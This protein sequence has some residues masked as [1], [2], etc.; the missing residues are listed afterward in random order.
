VATRSYNCEGKF[1]I[2]S[3]ESVSLSSHCRIP[4]DVHRE[5]LVLMRADSFILLIACANVA[6][7]LL[8]RSTLRWREIAF[9]TAPRAGGGRSV[10]QLLTES[11]LLALGGGA[12]GL[13]VADCCFAFLKSLIPPDL[14]PAVS[15][16][17]GCWRVGST[18]RW[19]YRQPGGLAFQYEG[20]GP[21]YLPCG[22][23]N[24]C[25]CNLCGL[26]RSRVACC[27]RGPNRGPSLRI[28]GL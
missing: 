23:C 26:L 13:L 5:L 17:S 1:R 2:S 12:L 3:V 8:S 14:A 22:S 7:L 18:E 4:R 15:V 21:S 16:S 27:P 19:H 6:N 25:G 24:I 9:G 10:R 20:A 11:A 28:R